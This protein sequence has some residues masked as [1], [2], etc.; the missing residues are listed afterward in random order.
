MVDFFIGEFKT[1]PLLPEFRDFIS[2]LR[3]MQRL[4]DRE[5]QAKDAKDFWNSSYHKDDVKWIVQMI[6]ARLLNE[7]SD[8][9]YSKF[10]ST[11]KEVAVSSERIALQSALS[12]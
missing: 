3:E 7:V 4:A 6:K 2:K 11:L 9:D 10:L 12:G 8:E 5:R 1:A